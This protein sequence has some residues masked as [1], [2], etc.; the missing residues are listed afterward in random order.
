[1]VTRMEYRGFGPGDVRLRAE[2][3]YTMECEWRVWLSNSVRSQT[4]WR[5]S[6]TSAQSTAREF[7]RTG[8]FPR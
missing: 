8:R 1:M 7:L 4:I 6:L 3:D 5:K 2:I